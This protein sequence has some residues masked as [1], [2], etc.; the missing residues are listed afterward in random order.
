MFSDAKRRA[1]VFESFAARIFQ[2]H[3]QRVI[4]DQITRGVLDAGRDAYGRYLLGLAD[5]PVYAE[6][7]LEAKCYRPPLNGEKPNTVGV[8]EVSRL[9]SRIRHREFGVLVTTSVVARQAYEE[10]RGDRHPIVFFSGKDI[11]EILMN[12]GYNEPV[13]VKNLLESEYPV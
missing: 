5:D 2:M 13:L 6:F 12:N 1:F 11:T 7:S 9:I 8:K 4:V 10:V 3:D